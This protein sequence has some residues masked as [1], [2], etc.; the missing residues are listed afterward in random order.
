MCVCDPPVGL[1]PQFISKT[2]KTEEDIAALRQEIEVPH[3]IV[4]PLKPW[5]ALTRQGGPG[6]GAEGRGSVLRRFAAVHVR[7]E[8]VVV[9]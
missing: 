1:S 9:G 6:L 8:P 7:V 3:C 4:L 2:G 5:H